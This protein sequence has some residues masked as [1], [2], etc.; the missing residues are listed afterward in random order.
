MLAPPLSSAL[1]QPVVVEN[2]P[3]AAANIGA[4]AVA[5]AN[6]GHTIGIIGNGP[7][8]SSQFLFPIC[9]TSRSRISPPW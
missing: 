7:L 6:D 4:D 9:R 8:T 3:G 5:K 2:R 1:G